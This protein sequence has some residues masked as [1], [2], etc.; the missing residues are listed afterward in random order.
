MKNTLS[1][2]SFFARGLAVGLTGLGLAGV[3]NAAAQ[4]FGSASNFTLPPLPYAEDALEPVISSEIM[5][6]HHGKHHAGYVRKLNAALEGTGVEG[7][8]AE[9]LSDLGSVPMRA[10]TKV[11]QN[12]GG[13]LNHAIFWDVMSP[14]GGGA[15]D[16]PLAEAIDAQ[17]G[18]FEQFKTDFSATAGSVFGSGWG[19]LAVDPESKELFITRTPNQNNPLMTGYVPRM[20][21]PILGIDVWEHAYYLQYKN[22]RGEYIDN[23]WNVVD[24]GNVSTRYEAALG[25]ETIVDPIKA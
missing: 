1:R 2:R 11:R 23:W 4:Y 5:R 7:D 16:G 20:G 15:P 18:G 17:L 14:D 3:R 24:W 13:A 21:V 12:G 22:R 9:I 10:R 19:W 8:L 25:G 6:L